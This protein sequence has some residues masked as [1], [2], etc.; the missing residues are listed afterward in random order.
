MEKNALSRKTVIQLIAVVFFYGLGSAWNEFWVLFLQDQGLSAAGC[1]YV[2]AAAGILEAIARPVSGAVADKI[3]QRHG[4][5]LTASIGWAVLLAAL[6]I[7]RQVRIAT[8]LL[9]AGIIP[10]VN[11]FEPVTYGMLEA[12]SVE[13]AMRT[14][15]LDFSTIRVFV[16]ISYCLINFAYTP[17]VDRFGSSAPFFMAACFIVIMILLSNGL[18]AFRR[19]S[20]EVTSGAGE[21]LQFRR[22]FKNYFLVTFV[23][24][25]FLTS[26]GVSTSN[27]LVYLIEAL[28]MGKSLVGVATGIRVAGEI[29]MM[30]LVPLIK[31]KISLP[32]LQ[33]AAGCMMAAQ[34]IVFIFC[35]NPVIVVGSCALSGLAGGITYG[36]IA[37]YLRAMAPEGLA[38]TTMALTTI[39]E[40]AGRITTSVVGGHIIDSFGIFSLYEFALYATILW[41]VLYFGTWGFGVGVLK[42][43]PVIPMFGR[44]RT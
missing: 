7:L 24:L 42:K 38:T 22:L 25:N 12:D 19:S 33:A 27:Y 20:A 43:K 9:C 35:K 8:F 15:K 28:G 3:R 6:V 26:L 5:F 41:L 44:R 14:P 36:T 11:L 37:V 17:I 34:M 1:G 30:P 40:C 4:I 18:R 32:L 23:L 21:K 29:V 13:A 16:S 31:R 39:M 10:I 2:L